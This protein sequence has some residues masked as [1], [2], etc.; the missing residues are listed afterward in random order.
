MK[1]SG[2]YL[3]EISFP[4]GG[5]GTGCIGIA[6]N[7]G[8]VDF[9]IFN[10]P[11]KGS[12]IQGTT[13]FA[14]CAK[15]PDGKIDARVI[16][17]DTDK[18][19]SGRYN[20]GSGFGHGPSADTMCGLP[21]FSSVTFDGRFP[22]AELTFSDETFPATV[23][24]TAWS[25]F[26]PLDSE[27]SSIPVACFDISIDS[28]R[29]DVEYTVFFS[30]KNPFGNTLNKDVS[31]DK[32]TAV[33]LC[34]SDK[35][36][37]DKDYGDMTVAVDCAGEICQ[38]YWYRGGGRDGV[39]TFWREL[40]SG[41]IHPRRYDEAGVRDVCTVGA[42]VEAGE[43]L[44]FVLSWNVPNRYNYWDPYVDESGNDVMW[45]N[46]YATRFE[47]SAASCFYTLDNYKTFFEKTTA[48][49]DALHSSTL[50]GAVIDA[51]SS[52]LSVLRSAT[53]MRLE[54]GALYGFEGV[55]EQDGSCEGTCTHVWSYAY[56]LCFLFPDLER[57]IRETEFIFDTA[58][59]GR[60]NFRTK[61]PLGRKEPRRPQ[62]VDGQMLSVVKT[63]REWKISGDDAWLEKYF[64][65][66]K[67]I[68]S[69][70]WS[71]ENYQS[72]DRDRDG[73]LEGQQHHTL[74]ADLFGPSS[75]LEGLYLLALKAAAEM[76]EYLGESDAAREYTLL[77]EK[78]YNYTKERLFNGEYFIQNT[79]IYDRSYIEKYG[80]AQYWNDEKKQIKYQIGEG[81]EIDQMLAQWHSDILGL[82][83][84]FD[85]G[86]RRA[87]LC[88]MMRYNFKPKM[89]D[90]ANVWRVFAINDESGTIICDYPDESKKPII[91]IQYCEECMTGFEY[92]FAGLLVA[93]GK[94]DD[95]LKVVRAV[96]DRYDGKKRNPY[97]EIECGSNYARSMAS[98]ALLPIFTGF[99]FDLP[100]KTIG[101]SPVTGGDFRCFFS[102][103]TGYGVYEKAGNV[104]NVTL[105]GGYLDLAS[106]TLG[107]CGGVSTVEIDGVPI[108]FARSGDTFSFEKTKVT[109]R[110]TF[111]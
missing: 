67:K 87:A 9:E 91:P 40:C 111:M 109:S 53:V 41:D 13:F 50:D 99:S 5:V 2:E 28:A 24:T 51:A 100:K 65:T 69:Y 105:I 90:V 20:G 71:E 35:T 3:S 79:D 102:V 88:S 7:G 84:I 83:D 29:D 89:R 76:A 68:L 45:K 48:F 14:I 23:K 22:T 15:Y 56:A 44:R 72:W 106:V 31:T 70:A 103:G 21:H 78:G 12:R 101:F 80:A 16:L 19:L 42:K 59:T 82:G 34:P 108:R 54:N 6:G 93:E 47:N 64:P 55:N 62:C 49:C 85:K 58:D 75:W 104:T 97:N 96:R 57:S 33:Y 46:Y 92:A 37:N 4:L 36:E 27:N 63:Y 86:Q 81:S 8:F 94:I 74:D 1:Y 25:P 17:G 60:M 110:L 107:G 38:E 95:G 30:V 43:P 66:V 77:F 73:V 10:R 39:S 32:Y 61:L 18:D 98:F 52:A 26:I 11:N